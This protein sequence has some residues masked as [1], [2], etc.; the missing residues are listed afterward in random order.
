MLHKSHLIVPASTTSALDRILP[1]IA[2]GCA[3]LTIWIVQ[4][5]YSGLVHD[6]QLYTLQALS[7][8]DPALYSRDVFLRFGSQD[9]FT[10]FGP[11]YAAVIRLLG[12]ENAA[13]LVTLVSQAAFLV[14]AAVLARAV[15]PART[16]WLGVAL[17]CVLP[18]FYGGGSVFAL[19]ENFATPRPGAQAAALIGLAALLQRRFWL[20]GVFGLI[21][22]ALHPLMAAGVLVAALCTSSVPPRVRA[23]VIGSGLIGAS[24]LF[25]W[26]SMRGVQIQFDEK[27]LRLLQAGTPYLFVSEWTVRAWAPTSIVAITL[28][29]G[30]L[31]LERSQARSLCKAGFIAGAVGVA[32]GYVAGDLLK[33]VVAV[34][35]QAWRW[36]WIALLIAIVLLPLIAQRL[37]SRGALG[38]AAILL[39]ATS[40]LCM[41]ELYG[42]YIAI[43]ALVVAL[44]AARN[45]EALAERA[46][47]LI[48]LG[49]ASLSALSV[50]YHIATLALFAEGT[51]DYSDVTQFLRDIRAFADG[52]FLSFTAF[53]LVYITAY[54]AASWR[55]RVGVTAGCVAVLAMLLPSALNEWSGREYDR[56]YAAFAE[57]RNLIAPGSEVLWFDAPVAAWVLLERPSYLSNSQEATGLFSRAAAM[58]MKGRVDKLEPFL[59]TELGAAWTDQALA[60][61]DMSAN[62]WAASA[63][64]AGKRAQA[65]PPVPLASLCSAAPDLR[66]IATSKNLVAQPYA[67]APPGVSAR[68]RKVQLYRCDPSHG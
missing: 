54:R 62:E 19:V 27:W 39:L 3:L 29:V 67:T 25:A 51:S 1:A 34:Q 52:G 24:A 61:L 17:L 46:R 28:L 21:S 15:M 16:A 37:W 49:A 10:I 20:A 38:R 66:F 45:N 42:L 18:G 23:W 6:S 63:A 33:I 7:H 59:A 9:R 13:V 56:N 50:I 44:M 36:T 22:L 31:A 64:E 30:I 4:H 55:G 11:L 60:Y 53:T 58:E 32:F 48:L 65:H 8:M 57:W 12:T 26:M 2:L 14:A 43:L 40:W 47:R 41:A 68:Y 35:G 5:S